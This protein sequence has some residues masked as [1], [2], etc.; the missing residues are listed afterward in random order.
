MSFGTVM[1]EERN[2]K[3][4][5]IVCHI[6]YGFPGNLSS[7]HA[8]CLVGKTVWA[9]LVSGLEL[10]SLVHLCLPALSHIL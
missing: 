1:H 10:S 2:A 3:G 7:P 9:G 5:H 6:S 4:G 8:C